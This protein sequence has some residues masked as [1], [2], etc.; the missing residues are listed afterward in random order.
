[1]RPLERTCPVPGT[2]RR[3]YSCFPAF[4]DV[5]LRRGDAEVPGPARTKTQP[6]RTC[7]GRDI[8][9]RGCSSS[10]RCRGSLLLAKEG[11]VPAHASFVFRLRDKCP[12]RG[13][14][15]RSSCEPKLPREAAGR[16]CL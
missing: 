5:S 13:M 9:Q 7:L 1:T 10:P 3:G 15:W 6:E 12:G 2:A 4:P 11:G 14:P 16:T 8:R